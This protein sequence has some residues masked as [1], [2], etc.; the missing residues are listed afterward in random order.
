M[1]DQDRTIHDPRDCPGYPTR[2]TPVEVRRSPY[3]ADGSPQADTKFKGY[4][5]GWK[6]WIQ[7]GFTTGEQNRS[8]FDLSLLPDQHFNDLAR[9]MMK[10]DAVAAIRAF[11]AAMQE[12]DAST[13]SADKAAA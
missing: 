3:S 12:F 4:L 13:D 1:S 2:Y 6:G 7:I 8:E 5:Q 9:A 11:G 10:A